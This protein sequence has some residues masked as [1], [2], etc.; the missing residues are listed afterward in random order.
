MPNI[1]PAQLLQPFLD[2]VFGFQERRRSIG[3]PPDTAGPRAQLSTS[4]STGFH[5]QE[6][7]PM[8][9]SRRLATWVAV[10][11]AV[12]LVAGAALLGASDLL[13][14]P[15]RSP[16][17]FPTATAIYPGDEVRV[18][19]VKVGTIDG[20]QAARAPR[21]RLVLKVDRDVPVPADAPRP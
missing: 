15:T 16:P 10:L 20:D 13:R 7:C 11:L 18:S 17:Y 6:I 9:A 3:Q 8:M 12:V 4:P 2:Y 14:G 19:G 21:P 1:Q 5:N